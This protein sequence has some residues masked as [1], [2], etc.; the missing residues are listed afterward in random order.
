MIN[1]RHHWRIGLGI[2]L[3]LVACQPSVAKEAPAPN[4]PTAVESTVRDLPGMPDRPTSADKVETGYF[5]EDEPEAVAATG[6]PQMLVFY[7]HEP[8]QNN[9]CVRCAPVIDDIQA[10]EAEYWDQI[11]F[12]YLNM[13]TYDLAALREKYGIASSS[14]ESQVNLILI[15]ADGEKVRRFAE[16]N[17]FNAP[18][19]GLNLALFHG[20]F[21]R[22]LEAQAGGH[23]SSVQVQT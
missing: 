1:V 2:G 15:E 6:R 21:N 10:L 12:V 8:G 20:Y 14:Y 4:A 23:L 11:D 18:G 13:A 9:I 22:Y 3:L 5:R 7:T 17:D 16:H 19:T